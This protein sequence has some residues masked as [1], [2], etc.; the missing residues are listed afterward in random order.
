M[1]MDKRERFKGKVVYT[2]SKKGGRME[3]GFIKESSGKFL[4]DLF[5][6]YSDIVTKDDGEFKILY[7]NDA[8]EFEVYERP[9]GMGARNIT[10]VDR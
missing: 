1:M 3:Y 5:F 6:I 10:K 9:R 4:H 2:A 7:E 8:V